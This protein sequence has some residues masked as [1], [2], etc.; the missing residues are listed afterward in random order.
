MQPLVH[1][2]GAPVKVD[3]THFPVDKHNLRA[4]QKPLRKWS[5]S[6][7][8]WT[9]KR[10]WG[11]T[12]YGDDAGIR[13]LLFYPVAPL[14]VKRVCDFLAVRRPFLKVKPNHSELD[15]PCRMQ[16]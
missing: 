12:W 5:H 13:H 3:N 2:S 9:K 14:L 7:L 10:P 15:E 8:A 11:A 4:V 1:S 16:S 6:W